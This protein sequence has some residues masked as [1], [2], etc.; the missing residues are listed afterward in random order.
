MEVILRE[1]E[2]ALSAQFFSPAVVMALTLPDTCAALESP[3]G[4]TSGGKYKDWYNRYLADA[5]PQIT[6][7][8]R[9]RRFVVVAMS[10]RSRFMTLVQAATKSL[11]NFFSPSELA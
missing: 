6:G 5:Y 11:T 2:R 1:I 4:K 8:T 3:N 7:K 10:N 9:Q